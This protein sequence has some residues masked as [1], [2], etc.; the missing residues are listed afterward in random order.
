M[1]DTTPFICH[2]SATVK[3]YDS[4]KT[5][6]LIYA[7][8]PHPNSKEKLDS[9]ALFNDFIDRYKKLTK[10]DILSLAQKAKINSTGQSSLCRD[11]TVQLERLELPPSQPDQISISPSRLSSHISDSGDNDNGKDNSLITTPVSVYSPS[12][13]SQFGDDNSSISSSVSVHSRSTASQFGDDTDSEYEGNS[14]WVAAAS[15]SDVLNNL[16][17]INQIE[18]PVIN[19]PTKIHSFYPIS[20]S[21]ISSC[22]SSLL[23]HLDRTREPSK[24]SQTTSECSES[25][26]ESSASSLSQ[27]I[28]KRHFTIDELITKKRMKMTNFR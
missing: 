23:S 8:K 11:V 28:N 21:G 19:E 25:T 18:S 17:A 6:L 13:A 4:S 14:P 12:T 27:M 9:D 10:I 20:S 3:F 2:S 1:S 15:Q 22:S 26:T 7:V 5:K 16:Y 24:S